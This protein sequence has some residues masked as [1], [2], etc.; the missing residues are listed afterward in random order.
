MFSTSSSLLFKHSVNGIIKRLQTN[1]FRIQQFDKRLNYK[2]F[3]K[4]SAKSKVTN[5]KN[6]LMPAQNNN[7]KKMNVLTG[8]G[9]VSATFAANVYSNQVL[10]TPSSTDDGIVDKMTLATS[11]ASSDGIRPFSLTQPKYDQSTF[12]GRLKSI[13]L[14]ID[15]RNVFISDDELESAQ[16]LLEKYKNNMLKEGEVTDETL[17]KARETVEAVIHKPTGEK[18]FVMGRM[19]AFILC[20]IPMLCGMMI[21]GP[22]STAAGMFWQWVNQS[23]NVVNNYTNRAGREVDNAS[24]LKT[25][26]IGVSVA[27]TIVF[28]S[29]QLIARVPAL[30]SLGLL[31]PYLA[32]ASAGGLNVTLTRMD[33]IQ[34]GIAVRDASGNNVGTSKNAGALAVYK[35]V[36][37]RSMFLPVAPMLLPPLIM[38]ALNM[39]PGNPALFVELSIIALCMGLALPC[40]LALLPEEMELD[41]NDLEK[42]FQNLKDS[43]GKQIKFLYAE[44]GL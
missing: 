39:R 26:G 40:A 12:E 3:S 17:W 1:K 7:N 23:Y 25:Y 5:G 4:S 6:R 37:T 42:E 32:V 8:I 10:A 21:H 29:N 30:K 28:V 41:V 35:T 18:M 16:K 15:P 19:S 9:L 2:Y 36:T 14:K 38:K 43:D 44:K 34:N 31:I 13:L 11:P 22:T 24:L 33:E 27:C 20:N